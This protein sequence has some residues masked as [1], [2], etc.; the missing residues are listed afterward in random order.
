MPPTLPIDLANFPA[1]QTRKALLILDLQNEFLS[2]SGTLPVTTPNGYVE[3]TLKI[4]KAFRESGSGDV[5][6][7]RSQFDSHR[8][9]ENA[10][11]ITSASSSI[12][13]PRQST[14]CGRRRESEPTAEDPDAD[15]EAFLSIGGATPQDKQKQQQQRS[16]CLLPGSHGSELAQQVASVVNARQDLVIA[17]S[18]YSAFESTQL[19]MR[20]RTRFVTELYICGA[21]TNISIHATALDAARHGL[22]LTIIEDCCGYRDVARHSDAISSLVQLTGCDTLSADHV[23]EGLTSQ[24][25]D[26][27]PAGNDFAAAIAAITAASN[28]PP[29]VRRPTK[30]AS[31]GP[32]AVG[33]GGGTSGGIPVRTKTQ[34]P[35]PRKDDK[36]SDVRTRSAP[37]SHENS[38]LSRLSPTATENVPKPEPETTRPLQPVVANDAATPTTTAASETTTKITATKSVATTITDIAATTTAPPV[39]TG[40][41][42]VVGAGAATVSTA[43]SAPASIAAAKPTST[44][45]TTPAPIE[46]LTIDAGEIS[47][48]EDAGNNDDSDDS[49]KL[50]IPSRHEKLLEYS[51][52]RSTRNANALKK[53]LEEGTKESASAAS[54]ASA[55]PSRVE[56][57]RV[58][59]S[60]ATSSSRATE[61]RSSNSAPIASKTMSTSTSPKPAKEA[62]PV[63]EADTSAKV[64]SSPVEETVKPKKDASAKTPAKP[65]EKDDKDVSKPDEQPETES[66]SEDADAK[67]VPVDVTKKPSA[68]EPICAGDTIIYHDVLPQS[69]EKGIY[70][71]LKDEVQ[72]LRMSHQG[73]EVP[74]LVCVQG[75]VDED[76]SIPIYRHPAD[77][78]PPLEAFTPTVVQIKSEVEKIVGHP[79]NHVLIQLYRTG[80]DYISEHSDKTLDIVPGSYVCNMSLGAERT[81]IFRTKRVDKDPSRKEE[82]SST[83]DPTDS[84]ATDS[85]A[86]DR[87]PAATPD[88]TKRQS[89]RVQ[90]P[91]NS[92]CRMGLQTN[93]QWLHA[94]RQDKRIKREKTPAELAYGGGRISLTFRQIG[95]FLNRDQTLIW[96]QGAVGK[97]RKEARSVVNGQS[98]EAIRMLQAFG[99]EN[100]S[101]VFDW[102]KHYGKGFDV[103]HMSSSPRFFASVDPVVNM[104]VQLLLAELGINYARGSMAAAVEKKD[105]TATTSSDVA[106]MVTPVSSLDVPVRLVD[107]DRDRSTVHGVLAILLYLDSMYAPP[108][109][110]RSAHRHLEAARKFTRLQQALLLQDKWRS[111]PKTVQTDEASTSGATSAFSLRPLKCE[112]AVWDG[113]VSVKTGPTDVSDEFIAGGTT[114]SV[115]DFALWPVLHSMELAAG[116]QDALEAELKRLGVPGLAKY[117]TLF[118]AR[119]CVEKVLKAGDK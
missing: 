45:Q 26:A 99:T 93:M 55:V 44:R 2:P 85:K 36:Q 92:L 97:T 94:I 37:S 35:E 115:A 32:V 80:N 10:Q 117:Y 90:L 62:S 54:G 24:S 48:D 30:Q 81:M 33:A 13:S 41:K 15:P 12:A 57:T 31:S 28:G 7:I 64:S 82:S 76:G 4:A 8:P 5:F 25:S 119:E 105:A 6:W 72:W 27:K 118:K 69:L 61:T 23:L 46:P 14:T 96:G 18:H 75:Q 113:Y 98:D 88:S 50:V 19:L 74:R 3:R 51:R 42:S 43:S 58:R 29:R 109:K 47:A 40:S 78:S 49:F 65:T 102:N 66:D 73:G 1:L 63:S 95:T 21:L 112:L 17:K 68:T 53:R 79:L 101:S 116:S 84:K 107:N 39:V 38:G 56:Q 22:T 111:T 108:P 106:E 110:G 89:C 104:T 67:L 20:L 86:A 100:H 71:R 52:L 83:T 103:L 34:T 9:T 114:P 16:Q 11:I 70:E 60:P 87:K 91:H 59:R 77:E